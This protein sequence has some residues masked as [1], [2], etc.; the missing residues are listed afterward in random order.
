MKV[1]PPPAPC[2]ISLSL[3]ALMMRGGGAARLLR[4]GRHP[5]PAPTCRSILGGGSCSRVP[6]LVATPPPAP[7]ASLA[8]SEVKP[9]EASVACACWS[10]LP[11]SLPCSPPTALGSLW[12]AAFKFQ[13]ASRRV[14]ARIRRAGPEPT[15]LFTHPGMGRDLR[16]GRGA[17]A[18]AA[19]P[20]PRLFCKLASP[21]E[22]T[23][24]PGTRN[25]FRGRGATSPP[26]G[27]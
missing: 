26:P 15:A 23:C 19:A 1:A 6:E 9:A 18:A 10:P 8:A 11:P 13:A 17:A 16:P 2:P 24:P 7:A 27:P 25:P 3:I 4:E 14:P 22:G 21:A 20:T 5:P 12:R